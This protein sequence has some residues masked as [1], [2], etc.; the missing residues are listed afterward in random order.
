MNYPIFIVA[1]IVLVIDQ[2]TKVLI[3]IFMRL[4]TTFSIIDNFFSLTYRQNYGAAW[5][6]FTGYT[7]LLVA[8]SVFGLLIIIRYIKAFKI[9][10]RNNLAFGFILGGIAGNLID[11]LFLGYVRDF[12]SLKFNNL[13]FPTFNVADTM[14][15][16]GVFLLII[17][18]IKG[19][20]EEN[21]NKSK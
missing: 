8:I 15:V 2:I 10:N 13:Y 11:R 7:G 17:A 1:V 4:N 19:E 18:I 6:L 3:N 16:I 21:V 12:I 20:D 14:I 5:G 9:N